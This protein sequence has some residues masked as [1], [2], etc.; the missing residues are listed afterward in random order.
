[1]PVQT[2]DKSIPRKSKVKN[3]YIIARKTQLGLMVFDIKS[4]KTIKEQIKLNLYKN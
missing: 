3:R 2:N 1:M 4:T